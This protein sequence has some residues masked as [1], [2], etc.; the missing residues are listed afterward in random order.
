MRNIYRETF[1]QV[2]APEDLWREIREIPAREQRPVRRRRV[3][4]GVLAAVLILALTGTALAAVYHV[5][6]RNFTPE[7]LAETGADHAYKVLTDV[8]RTPL[9]AFSQEALDAA[10]GAERFWEREFDTWAEAEDFLGTR[11]PGVEAPAA[12]QLKTRNGELAEAELRS[13]PLPLQTPTDRLNIGVRA[14]L[15]TENYV[16]EPGDNTF[17]YYGLPDPNYS[18]EREDLRYQLPDGEE[19]VMVSTWD[20]DSGGVDAFL[21][22]GNIRYWVYAT[23]VLYD[24]ETVLEEVEFILQ[25]L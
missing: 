24:R 5:E 15:Y 1:E 23:Y 22:R 6:I 4:G 10:A 17:L 12:L 9:E 14:T 21:V 13:Y 7:Q 25:N 18:M 11:V 19:A 16:E 20:D 3:S 2:R 8:E